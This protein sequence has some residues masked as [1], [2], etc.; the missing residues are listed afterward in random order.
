MK[1]LRMSCML[2]QNDLTYAEISWAV[3]RQT[4][5]GGLFF[6]V[7]IAKRLPAEVHIHLAFKGAHAITSENS[8]H[9]GKNLSF[10]LNKPPFPVNHFTVNV[11]V[12]NGNVHST[13]FPIESN[14]EGNSFT[15]KCICIHNSTTV[16]SIIL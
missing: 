11:T 5:D 8:F 6:I 7:H 16:K 1:K 3:V 2:Y 13:P 9:G 14:G 10:F 12:R 15:Y 4:V